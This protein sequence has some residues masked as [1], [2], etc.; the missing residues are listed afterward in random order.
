MINRG[1][2]RDIALRFSSS[3]Q[4]FIEEQ[5]E[6]EMKGHIYIYIYKEKQRKNR[7][8]MVII[9]ANVV[10]KNYNRKES[11]IYFFFFIPGIIRSYKRKP[12]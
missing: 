1:D 8:F 3:C 4:F 5:D 7:D 6:R 10:R 12:K 11:W 2:A 9:S